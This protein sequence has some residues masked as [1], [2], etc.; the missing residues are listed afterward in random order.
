MYYA[1]DN[2]LNDLKV[3]KKQIEQSIGIPDALVCIARG[4]MTLTHML[5]LAWNIRSVYSLNAI[6]YNDHKVQSSLILENM[7][8]IKQEHKN[9]L[10]LDEIV[11]SGESLDVV[12]Q[13]LRSEFVGTKFSSAVIFQKNNAKIKADFFIR[14]PAEWV[15]F[16]WEVD[17]LKSEKDEK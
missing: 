1:Y 2:F 6:S 4:G 3:L 12:L 5:S 16:F 14:E 13:K 15:D 17:L 9:V 7:P 8:N 11:D 10:V